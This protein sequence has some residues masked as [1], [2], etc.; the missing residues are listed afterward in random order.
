MRIKTFIHIS[1]LLDVKLS[2]T[3]SDARIITSQHFSVV[4]TRT[5]KYPELLGSFSHN[6]ELQSTCSHQ[7]WIIRVQ[8]ARTYNLSH[9]SLNNHEELHIIHDLKLNIITFTS[10]QMI[11]YLNDSEKVSI[12]S[13]EENKSLGVCCGKKS[14]VGVDA[15]WLISGETILVQIQVDLVQPLNQISL[16]SIID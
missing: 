6:H 10:L 4:S 2:L 3:G 16:L 7:I 8:S 5:C 9:P 13:I 15:D 12:L 1:W 11:W 14:G